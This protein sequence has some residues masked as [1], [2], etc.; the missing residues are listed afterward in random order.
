LFTRCDVQPAEETAAPVAEVSLFCR[1][2]GDSSHCYVLQAETSK[3]EEKKAEK[4]EKPHKEG[5]V[6]K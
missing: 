2:L 3:T 5:I 4:A 6:E 1:H